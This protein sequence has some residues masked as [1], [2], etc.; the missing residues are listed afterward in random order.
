M[1]RSVTKLV[2]VLAILHCRTVASSPTVA[3]VSGNEA[4]FIRSNQTAAL[5]CVGGKAAIRGSNNELTITG[6]CSSLDLSGSN[7]KITAMLDSVGGKAAI[8]GSNNMLTITASVP[9]SM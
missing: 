3:Q 7:N 4:S 8:G 2:L 5:D 6:K 9:A 1:S